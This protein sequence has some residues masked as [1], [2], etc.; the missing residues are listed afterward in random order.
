MPH[1]KSR[2]AALTVFEDIIMNAKQLRG[3][4]L[5]L[6]LLLPGSGA[7][8]AGF[9]VIDIPNTLENIL[10]N[11]QAAARWVEEKGLLSKEMDLQSILM[12]MKTDND[13]NRSANEILRTTQVMT[14]VHNKQIQEQLASPP[15]ACRTVDLAAKIADADCDRE[16]EKKQARRK[17]RGKH[18]VA[19]GGG[20]YS[21]AQY[22]QVVKTEAK[23]LVDACGLTVDKNGASMA[24]KASE[25]VK[26]EYLLGSEIDGLNAKGKE[27]V[28][29]QIDIVAGAI[30]SRGT[31]PRRGDDAMANL[32]RINEA[33]KEWMRAAV[34]ESLTSIAELKLAP[35]GK[36]SLLQ[37][38]QQ[39]A[40]EKFG[41]Y[42]AMDSLKAVTNTS[43]QKA[44]GQE[45]S[46]S[47]VVRMTGQV[48][49][50]MVW[51]EVMKFKQ[52]L[53]METLS[54][55]MLALEADKL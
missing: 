5:A 29:R 37:V 15:D 43:P 20:G 41:S 32:N 46:V 48:E 16:A 10:G 7:M 55:A 39:Y 13:N 49:N 35:A 25:C 40:D 36:P 53:R 2:P 45:T 9:P 18:G 30:P 12:G 23:Q 22:Q 19:S 26:S 47:Q 1:S 27:I 34:Q 8:A 50:F 51:M 54:A 11:L 17:L 52:Q 24:G 33:R 38:M 4:A 14:D 21:P 6:A 31:D 42:D 44:N 28:N 3:A